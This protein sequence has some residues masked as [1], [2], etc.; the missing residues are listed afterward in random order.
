MFV[1]NRLD[2]G[3]LVAAENFTTVH[4]HNE[5]YEVVMGMGKRYLHENYTQTLDLSKHVAMV[6][7]NCLVFLYIE[8]FQLYYSI[9]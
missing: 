6:I 4:L 2:W 5:L 8:L 1:T 9:F 7:R 3:H